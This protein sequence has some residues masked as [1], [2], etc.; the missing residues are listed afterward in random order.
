MF[1]NKICNRSYFI[2]AAGI[3]NKKKM[4]FTVLMYKNYIKL[5]LKNKIL[6]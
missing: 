1:I 5:Y 6:E 4:Y 2:K 3:Y